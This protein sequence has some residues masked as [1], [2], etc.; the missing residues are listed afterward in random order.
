MN[1]SALPTPAE[2]TL[3]IVSATESSGLGFT[4]ELAESGHP[5]LHAAG[6][7][8]P[9]L[10]KNVS[11]DLQWYLERLLDERDDAALV[12]AKHIRDFIKVSGKVLFQG[13]FQANAEARAIWRRIAPR[14]GH[15]RI[16]I[17][18]SGEN[19]GLLWELLRDPTT[20]SPV[21]LSA[22]A[23]VRSQRE[24]FSSASVREVHLP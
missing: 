7:L 19:S 21:C 12:R 24:G 6:T 4:M 1:R 17:V 2:M 5:A 14:L 18:E 3:R 11:A 15:T 13:L 10:T 20:N 8:I 16:E 22:A 23:F 9:Q